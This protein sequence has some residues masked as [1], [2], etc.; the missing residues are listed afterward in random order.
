MTDQQWFSQFGIDPTTYTANGDGTYTFTSGPYTGAKLM[1]G[2][3]VPVI[4]ADGGKT[5][6]A[7]GHNGQTGAPFN[8]Q[9]PLW[10]TALKGIAPWAGAGLVAPL[11]GGGSA[12]AAGA[13]GADSGPT[14]MYATDPTTGDITGYAPGMAP[15]AG[16]APGGSGLNVGNVGNLIGSGLGL[17]LG[18]GSSA[19]M[20]QAEAPLLA[21][22]NATLPQLQQRVNET[23][24]LFQNVVNMAH[25][26]LPKAY[27]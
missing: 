8:L 26:M 20:S 25:G 17:G 7:I 15:G 1:K 11:L 24:P 9:T 2:F 5:G 16:T 21:A 6:V 14:S 22:L 4:S 10:Q 13:G 12:A 27:Q 18:L 19:S 23:Q 3:G